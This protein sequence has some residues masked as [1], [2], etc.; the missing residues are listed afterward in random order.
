MSL[1]TRPPSDSAL[2]PIAVLIAAMICF[3]TGAALAKTLIPVVGASGAVALRLGF[4][5]LMLWLVW[6]PWR[7]RLRAP[8]ARTLVMYGIALGCMNLLFYSALQRIPLGIAVALEFTGPLAVA[9]ASSNRPLDF[10]WIALAALGLLML[11]PLGA[12]S[13]VLDPVGIACALGAGVCWARYIVFGRRA[14]I[15][16]GGQTTAIG[17]L[18]GAIVIVPFG[19]A[20]AGSR[21]LSPAI[22]PAALGVALLS[23]ALPYSLEM[24]AM[25]RLPTRTFGVLLSLDPALGALSGL[26]FLGERLTWLQWAAIG[27]IVLASAGS[28]A[29]SRSTPAP[30]PLPE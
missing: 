7:M 9:M 11:L 21:L 13:Q 27:S 23:S 26:G 20:H 16:H 5:T 15:Q 29:T 17:M 3:Q 22:L 1:R 14:G 24:F 25:T 8:A 2:L 30:T 18:I 12:A 19:V 4:A 6:R 28:A 10:L